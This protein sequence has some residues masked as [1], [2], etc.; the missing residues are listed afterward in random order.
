MVDG[1]TSSMPGTRAPQRAAS[2]ICCRTVGLSP[3]CHASRAPSGQKAVTSSLL[4]LM[5]CV[6]P[7]R[8]AL[9]GLL[10]QGSDLFRM[11]S[12]DGVAPA[13][14]ASPP[15]VAPRAAYI[16]SRS[17]LMIRSDLATMYQLGLSFQAGL[18]IGVLN[19][20]AAVNPCERAS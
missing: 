4:L 1:S 6:S 7:L 3:T 16:R 14:G 17:G 2:P 15:A 9:R 19:T 10:D 20:F 12:I 8:C 11:G 13:R 5:R 18:V